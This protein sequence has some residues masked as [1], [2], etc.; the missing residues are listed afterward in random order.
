MEK[1]N[2][3]H[4]DSRLR[5]RFTSWLNTVLRRAKIDYVRQQ[6]RQV[7]TVSMED[8]SEDQL[9]VEDSCA[10]QQS[11][12]EF[13]EERLAKAFFSLSLQR[14]QVLT[15]LFVDEMNPE[16]IA[17]VLHCSVNYVHK[18]KQRAL[19]SLRKMLEGREDTL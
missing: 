7:K 9:A 13:E 10:V 8:V 2:T 19:Q 4:E 12:F 6:E 15:M 18:V 14:Q 16:E 3:G 5:S 11:E 1:L 17:K